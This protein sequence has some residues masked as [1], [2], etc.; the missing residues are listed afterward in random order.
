MNCTKPRIAIA[1]AVLFLMA[2]IAFSQAQSTPG[3]SQKTQSGGMTNMPMMAGN[4]GGGMMKSCPSMG[5]GMC[6]MMMD[7]GGMVGGWMVVSM[8]LR[9]AL[10]LAAIFALSAAGLFLLR[11]SRV[12][13]VPTRDVL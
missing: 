9:S 11:R 2:S 13:V 5:G 1:M 10:A 7:G 3:T 6:P 12:T 4:E 8:I